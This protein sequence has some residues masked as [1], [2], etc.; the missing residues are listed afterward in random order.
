MPNGAPPGG[1]AFGAAGVG[2]PN[3]KLGTGGTGGGGAG[4]GAGAGCGAAAAAGVAAGSIVSGG[5][6]VFAVFSTG[7]ISYP[8]ALLTSTSRVRGGRFCVAAG[9]VGGDS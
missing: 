5:A 4:R 8:A 9:S 2:A 3:P 7:G 1:G 6:T